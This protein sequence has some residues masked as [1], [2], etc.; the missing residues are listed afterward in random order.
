MV[1]WGKWGKDVRRVVKGVS[2]IAKELAN[3]SPTL[4]SAKNGDLEALIKKAMVSAT[5]LS[6]LTKGTL[7][8]FTNNHPIGTSDSNSNTNTRGQD[9]VVYFTHEQ[10]EVEAAPPLPPPSSAPAAEHEQ[11]EHNQQQLQ[12]P[13]QQ[14]EE[15]QST[16]V[17]VLDSAKK[18][19]LVEQEPQPQ[20]WQRRKPRE[21]RVPSTPFSRALGSLLFSF[22]VSL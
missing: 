11:E 10:V 16:T 14:Q 20:P 4:Q 6:G 18:G 7:S 19:N 21:R 9:S 12:Q 15:H 3:R 2:L 17:E 8:Q 13:V 5:D 1:S 22:L